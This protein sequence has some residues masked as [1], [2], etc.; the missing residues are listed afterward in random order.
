MS[1]CQLV[2]EE[3][4][5]WGLEA[6]DWRDGFSKRQPCVN[7]ILVFWESFNVKLLGHSFNIHYIQ[8][9]FHF[10]PIHT[11]WNKSVWMYMQ[12]SFIIF[13]N[14]VG[15]ERGILTLI[16]TWPHVGNVPEH[17]RDSLH[18]YKS[19]LKYE[20]IFTCFLLYQVPDC[21]PTFGKKEE[22]TP[23]KRWGIQICVMWGS[24]CYFMTQGCLF[25][26]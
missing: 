14:M 11:C 2:S 21:I 18:V 5:A 1:S 6:P 4:V 8:E 22:E 25:Q 12:T 20:V 9:Q 17:Y 19:L 10:A 16:H 7:K 3:V 13:R 15:E 26:S 23:Q 24:V